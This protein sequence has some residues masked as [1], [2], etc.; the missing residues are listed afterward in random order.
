VRNEDHCI[1]GAR[2]VA[3]ILKKVIAKTAPG[4]EAFL[5]DFL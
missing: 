1:C 3:S 2:G 5:P 4:S